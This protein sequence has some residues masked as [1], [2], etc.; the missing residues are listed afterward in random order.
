[1][2]QSGPKKI[3][4]EIRTP[5]NPT[6]FGKQVQHALMDL[7]S[8]EIVTLI[9]N[10]DDLDFNKIRNESV[11]TFKSDAN[12]KLVA[13]TRRQFDGDIVTLFPGNIDENTST[14]S[15]SLEKVHAD[16]VKIA[17]DGWNT[18]VSTMKDIATSIIG[19]IKDNKS[20]TSKNE[21]SG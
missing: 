5:T 18:Y 13:Y 9:G 8:V 11:D 17:I 3:P 4:N 10:L 2:S 7:T 14:L 16:N 21:G 1:M 15:P 12:V 20:T 19:L 6:S